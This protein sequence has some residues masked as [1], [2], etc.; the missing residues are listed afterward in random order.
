MS[1]VLGLGIIGAGVIFDMH[2]VACKSLEDRI[3]LV[4]IADIDA[5]KR[6]RAAE[7]FFIP[8]VCTDYHELLARE[9]IDVISVCTPPSFHEEPVIAALE[10]GKYVLCE[11]PLAHTLQSADRII[12]VARR[13]PGKLSI[14]YQL[15][16]QPEIQKMIW[17]RDEGMLGKLLF[18]D[19]NRYSRLTSSA[20]IKSGWW[21]KWDVAG[22]GV[23]MTQFIHHLDQMCYLFGRPVEVSA[24]MDT[25]R[26]PIESEDT[27]AATVRF[28]GGALVSCCSSIA[29]QDF[30]YAMNVVG[31]EASVHLPWQIKCAD[32]RSRRR[33]AGRLKKVFADTKAPSRSKA[34]IFIRKV[35][36]RLGWMNAALDLE[37]AWDHS[38][39][40]K[41]AVA[42]IQS[43][44]P[45]P[46]SPE[47]ARL[48]LELCTAIYGSAMLR[49]PLE[50]PLDS[51]SEFYGGITAQQYK[52]YQSQFETQGT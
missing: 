48:S 3:R 41:A 36:R 45:L 9:D 27:F 23:I 29:A 28:E 4:G 35:R 34:A 44:S 12:E 33:M 40:L 31:T 2:A 47:E 20:A 15:R 39:Y 30:T 1:D 26:E 19:F 42:A 51:T 18:G 10:A 6:T 46:I 8:V 37:F 22:G 24:M 14:V 49:R 25:L 17:L 5:S 43:K 11:K 16:Y 50:L 7:R 13:Y 38:Q 21:G 32:K 52:S